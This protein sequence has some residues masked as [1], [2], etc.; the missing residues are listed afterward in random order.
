MIRDFETRPIQQMLRVR[1]AWAMTSDANLAETIVVEAYKNLLRARRLTEDYDY[2]GS[3]E[4]SQHCIELSVKA[5]HRLVGL[6]PPRVHDPGK[7]LTDVLSRLEFPSGWDF[8]INRL[9]RIRWV[10]EM[11]EF[12]H[13]TAIYGYGSSP[14]SQLFGSEDAQ[15]AIKYAEQV[16]STCSEVITHVR[17]G[18]VKTRS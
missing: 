2:S 9:G 13:S 11:W 8:M 17:G 4:A 14:A 15:T 1:C 12:A 18:T 3:V 6:D 10:S 7:F 5:L 16:Q